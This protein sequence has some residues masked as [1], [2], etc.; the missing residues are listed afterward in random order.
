MDRSHEY[1][2]RLFLHWLNQR[3]R[4]AF[5]PSSL[6]GG[7]FEARDSE[8]GSLAL[9]PVDLFEASEAWQRR[10]R[11]LSQRLD[12]TRP[13]S[14]LLW[15]P[16]GG[17]LPDGEPDESEFVRR[18]VLAASKLASGRSGEVRLPVRMALGKVRDE[19]GYASVTG[20]LGRHW[21]RIA[22]KLNGSYYLDSRGLKR[23]TTNEEERET[24]YDHIAMLSQGLKRG[25]ITE[26]EH[27]DAWSLQRLPRG[28][29]A[30]DMTDG[31]AIT[32]SPAGFDANDGSAV[33]RVL[34]RSLGQATETLA[35]IRGAT[36]GLVLIGGYDYMTG[37]NAG[38]S[39]RGFDP[40]LTAPFDMI[41]LVAD[42]EVKPLR[43]SRG[44][45][46][47]K[48]PSSA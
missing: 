33:R 19:G 10:T 8:A 46:F 42:A 7:H 28:P 43:M 24:L 37:E 4:R 20:G 1:A 38:P 44:L 39:L 11:E 26:F 15:V 6:D 32:G 21:T 48:E 29:A 22:E 45:S 16:P 2:V 47:A 36:K 17:D 35:S 12:D 18:V 41:G 14:Y 30:A 5:E 27:E 9:Y 40:S 3:Y 13:G 31:W 25:D 34:R 23:F